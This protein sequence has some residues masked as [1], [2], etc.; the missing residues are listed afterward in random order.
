LKDLRTLIFVLAAAC[1]GRTSTSLEPADASADSTPRIN[2]YVTSCV[3]QA[4]GTR[5]IVDPTQCTPDN[6]N[7]GWCDST[8][9]DEPDGSTSVWCRLP[10]VACKVPCS[11]DAECPPFYGQDQGAECKDPTFPSALRAKCLQH[12]CRYVHW[13]IC[14]GGG[15]ASRYFHYDPS[16]TTCEQLLPQITTLAETIHTCTPGYDAGLH[17]SCFYILQ[18]PCC[19]FAVDDLLAPTVLDY[20]GRVSQAEDLGC[21]W[22]T[23]PDSMCPLPG[24]DHTQCETTG[25]RPVCVVY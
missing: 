1:A 9:V 21:N 24:Y 7:V 19:W 6:C 22:K 23:C 25:D 16:T 18:A 5:C 20:L 3:G 14:P 4:C 15:D 10:P 13:P 8:P 17:G 2:G 12:Y 11:D